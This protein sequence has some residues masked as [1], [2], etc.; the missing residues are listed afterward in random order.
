MRIT[1][2]VNLNVVLSVGRSVIT[3]ALVNMAKRRRRGRRE[4]ESKENFVLIL[5]LQWVNIC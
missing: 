2:D 1:K 3:G 4:K 5:T